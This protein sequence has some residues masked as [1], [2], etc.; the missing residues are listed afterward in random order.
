MAKRESSNLAWFL[1]GMTVGAVG[2]ILYAPRSGRETREAL[3]E[4]TRRSR[5]SLERTGRLA[6]ERG[7]EFYQQGRR[8]ADEA[9]ESGR[10][11]LERGKEALGKWKP[12]KQEDDEIEEPLGV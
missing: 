1:A 9:A 3:G 12:G 5:E 2:A 4:T 6:A 10:E 11:A 8:F 7:R